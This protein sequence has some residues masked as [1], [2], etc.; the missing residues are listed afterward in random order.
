MEGS[1]P[2]RFLF[3]GI[4]VL[5]AWSALWFL[6]RIGDR[7]LETVLSSPRPPAID[8]GQAP[9]AIG[10]AYRCM[11][12]W[13]YAAYASRADHFYPPNHPLMPVRVVRPDRCYATLGDAEAAGYVLAPPSPG[14][15]VVDGVYLV[16]VNPEVQCIQAAARVGFRVPCPT[17]LPNPGA[18][19]HQAR[20]GDRTSFGRFTR[21]PCVRGRAFLLDQAG[22]GVPPGYGA[23][24]IGGSHLVISASRGDDP[25][26]APSILRCPEA[27]VV[28]SSVVRPSN[29]SRYFPALLLVCP[30]GDL[31]V[32]EYLVLGW[33]DSGVVYQ[34]AVRGEVPTNRRLLEAI[35]SNLQLIGPD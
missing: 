28:G 2:T 5:A 34:V 17:R 6:G 3:A 13:P 31:L 26:V 14:G 21:P 9:L 29:A 32:D 1:R 25:G 12:G 4:A 35:A 20:C 30:K 24:A 7:R 16:F 8:L 15:L 19:S 27:R 22:F 18:G 33:S 11:P 23:G 10:D